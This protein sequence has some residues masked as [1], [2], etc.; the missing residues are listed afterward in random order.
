MSR[1]EFEECSLK[2]AVY[3]EINGRVLMLGGNEVGLESY[4]GE[5]IGIRCRIDD[6]FIPLGLFP[7]LG[8][9]PI[10]ETKREPIEF[11]G[12]TRYFG[13]TTAHVIHVPAGVPLYA[14][15]KC[16]QILKEGE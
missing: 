9:K 2:D 5:W 6:T 7:L 14:T 3:V 16:V 13:Q 4:D 11:I 12:Y 15:F 10:R 1:I 8:I